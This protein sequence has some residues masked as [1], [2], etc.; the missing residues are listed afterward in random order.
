MA[1]GATR[2]G[3]DDELARTVVVI[4]G[5]VPGVPVVVGGAGV[6]SAVAAAATGAEHWSGP[7]ASG[8]LDVLDAVV[9]GRD[10]R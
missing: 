6:P 8:I 9:A 1:A 10:R 4:H 3:M 5:A 2:A 7:E